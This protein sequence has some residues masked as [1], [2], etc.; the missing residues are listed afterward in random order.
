MA[1]SEIKN[2]RWIIVILLFFA[3]TINFVDR[4]VIGLLKSILEI[5]I[6]LLTRKHEVVKLDDLI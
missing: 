5:A 1:I 4:Q 2:Y 6:H 3:T